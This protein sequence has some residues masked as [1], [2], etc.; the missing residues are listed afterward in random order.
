MG[1]N[2][3]VN[4]ESQSEDLR[5]PFIKGLLERIAETER[6]RGLAAYEEQRFATPQE[7]MRSEPNLF[8]WLKLW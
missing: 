4:T 3:R 6:K 7:P 1:T 2:L 8:T 5:K